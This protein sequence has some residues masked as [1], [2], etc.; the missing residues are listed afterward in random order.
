[1]AN[2][3]SLISLLADGEFHSGEEIGRQLGISRAAVWKQLQKLSEYKLVVESIKGKGYCL[4]QKVE[5]LNQITIL[6]SM[7]DDVVAKL[8]ALEV[9]FE[10][11]S[12]NDHALKRV[13]HDDLNCPYVCLAEVQKK[14]R[15][16]RGRQWMSALGSGLCLSVAWE[17][18]S[19]ASALEGLSLAVGIAVVRALMSM[20][21]DSAKLKWPNDILI[22]EKKL[23]GI[24]L[25]MTDDPAG[26]C[27][28]IIGVGVNVKADNDLTIDQPWIALSQLKPDVSRNRLVAAILDHLISLMQSYAST[29]F[30]PY[31]EEWE[32]VDAYKGCLVKVIAG[33]RVTSGVV[34]GVAANG[35][36]LLNVDGE[37]R[38]IYGG[39]LSLR[40]HENT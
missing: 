24:L 5:L 19:G 35:A 15:G 28:V 40:L 21:I 3:Q 38:S 4:S 8:A 12:T 34:E 9:L 25:E 1:M 16:R 11:D 7:N 23:G 33:E 29:G 6:E 30:S 39:E 36:L 27:Q 22:D 32:A 37:Q 20:G 13:S 17:F 2:I 14:G 26:R 10:L 18:G 31:R